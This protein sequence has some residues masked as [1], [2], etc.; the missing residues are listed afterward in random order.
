MQ[1]EYIAEEKK[2]L[3]THHKEMN[4]NLPYTISLKG[5]KS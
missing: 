4:Y 1:K 3:H 5:Q 2:N